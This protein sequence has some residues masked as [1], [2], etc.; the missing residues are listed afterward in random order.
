MLLAIHLVVVAIFVGLGIVFLN[1]KGSFLI[2][3]YN[4][5]SKAEKEK[6]DEKKLCRY[7]GKLMLVL[8]GCFLVIAA[9]DLLGKVWLLWLGLALFVLAAIG[10]VIWM[11]TGNRLKK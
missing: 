3:G 2:A 8:A 4:T 1:G 6:T 11:N 5:A 9:S 7:T 10:G